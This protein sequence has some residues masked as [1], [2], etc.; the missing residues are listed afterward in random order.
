MSTDTEVDPYTTFPPET[1]QAVDGLMWLGHLEEEVPFCGHRFLLRTLKASEELEASLLAKEYQ[2]TFGQIKAHA[3]AHLALSLVAVDGDPDFCPPIGP[4][5]RGYA[6]ARFN[7]ITE[8]YWPV[9]QFLFSQFAELN[10][11]QAA[12]V[13]A[14]ED[15]SSRSLTNSWPSADSSTE[16]GD[17]Q[18][19][20]TESKSQPS[21]GSPD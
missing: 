13:E 4:D 5:K 14:V 12:A 2:D 10:R 17:S 16:P 8:W 3:W 6:R 11:R 18:V 19:T 1:A 21:D 7:Y 9:G 20:S 15:L